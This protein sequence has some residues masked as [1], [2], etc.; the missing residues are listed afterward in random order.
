MTGRQYEHA[1]KNLGKFSTIEGFWQW[2][3]SIPDVSKLPYG[4]NLRLFKSGIKPLWEDPANEKGGKWT[5]KAP[6]KYTQ[7]MWS[8]LL[9]AVVGEQFEHSDDL[10]KIGK[11]QSL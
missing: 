1:M 4:T 9:L 10:V 11:L 7:D 5:I 6:K 3:N 2:T 8:K